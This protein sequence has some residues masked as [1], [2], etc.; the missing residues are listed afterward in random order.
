M[1]VSH[2]A[3]S[4]TWSLIAQ[5]SLMAQWCIFLASLGCKRPNLGGS[6]GGPGGV[7]GNVRTS[8]PGAGNHGQPARPVILSPCL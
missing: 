4:A 2:M 6:L 3:H 8:F 7:R 5:Y 1:P